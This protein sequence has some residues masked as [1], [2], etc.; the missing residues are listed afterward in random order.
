MTT[1]TPLPL[2][3]SALDDAEPQ[4]DDERLWS[5]TTMLDVIN[6]PALVAWAANETARFAV[7]HLS[8]LQQLVK[9]DGLDAAAEYLA[10]ARFKRAPGRTMSAKDLGSAVHA[11]CE[12]YV[13]DGRRPEKLDDEV[14][15]FVYQFERFLDRY[16]PEYLAAEVSVYAPDAGYA[17]TCDGFFTIDGTP[18]IFDYKTSWES[19]DARGKPK[20]PFPEVA[21]QLAAYRYAEFAAVWRARRHTQYSRRYYLLNPAERDL[22]V[23]LPQVAGGVAILLS[24]DRYAV[25]NVNCGPSVYE[26]FLDV[27]HVARWQHNLAN[28]AVGGE[29]V[30]PAA[31]PEGDPFAGLPQ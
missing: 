6:K 27:R 30:P 9:D 3:G 11:A 26:A 15:P 22:G 8:T 18:L 2:L 28:S 20:K 21:L 12:S 17:G 1:T 13:I 16:Q 25:H 4:P 19:F 23:P 29:R 31:P 24:P 5:V 7:S 10:G 14:K